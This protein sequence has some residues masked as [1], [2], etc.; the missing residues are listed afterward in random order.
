MKKLLVGFILLVFCACVLAETDPPAGG[1]AAGAG[2]PAGKSGVPNSVWFV[3]GVVAAAALAAS[4]K[5]NSSTS[6]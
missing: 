6:H 3:V 2:A 5:S 1:A 4:G